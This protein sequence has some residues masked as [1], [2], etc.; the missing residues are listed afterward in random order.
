MGVCKFENNLQKQ[1]LILACLNTNEK[2]IKVPSDKAY[3]WT[4]LLQG[5]VKY[6][7]L[8]SGDQQRSGKD[9][10]YIPW[11]ESLVSLYAIFGLCWW[12]HAVA[13]F[14]VDY[15]FFIFISKL[16]GDAFPVAA[17]KVEFLLCGHNAII[18]LHVFDRKFLN[19]KDFLSREEGDIRRKSRTM[20]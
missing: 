6:I 12:A 7:I 16:F 10:L 14:V 17:S 2:L 5:V 3:D 18:A 1:L 20:Q 19:S 9:W 4:L 8:P 15:L 11:Y 13:H